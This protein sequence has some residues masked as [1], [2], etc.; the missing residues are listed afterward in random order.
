MNGEEQKIQLTARETKCLLLAAQDKSL[1]DTAEC[2]H[3]EPD[4]VKKYRAR[5]LR[6]LGCQTMVGALAIAIRNNLFTLTR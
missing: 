6:K 2:M 4:T 1:N 5:I 3:V